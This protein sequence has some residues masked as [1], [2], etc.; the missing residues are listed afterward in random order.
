MSD[1]IFE[2]TCKITNFKWNSYP[3]DHQ[4]FISIVI[5]GVE[6]RKDLYN[7]L[8]ATYD[9]P[10]YKP[11]NITSTSMIM[12]EIEKQTDD[13]LIVVNLSTSNEKDKK[14]EYTL[15]LSDEEP[16]LRDQYIDKITWQN[17]R[18]EYIIFLA[19][20]Y[21]DVPAILMDRCQILFCIPPSESEQIIKKYSQSKATIEDGVT[22]VLE[23]TLQ[24]DIGVKVIKKGI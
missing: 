21:S 19:E 16:W 18:R 11:E 20:K 14:E 5:G 2:Q 8:V 3:Y 4:R 17:K 23:Y 22:L 24:Q 1:N 10:V 12:D 7:K 13:Y 9:F 6:E 15:D